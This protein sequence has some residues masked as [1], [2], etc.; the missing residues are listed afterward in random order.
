MFESNEEKDEERR[1][2]LE[3]AFVNSF[4]L[5]QESTL[6]EYLS[7][8]DG[9]VEVQYV[10]DAILSSQVSKVRLP[11]LFPNAK[12]LEIEVNDQLITQARGVIL[13]YALKE[14]RSTALK[15]FRTAHPSLLPSCPVCKICYP[16]EVQL[17]A[18]RT[19]NVCSSLKSSTSS[20]DIELQLSAYYG[21]TEGKTVMTKRLIYST[22]LGTSK[23]RNSVTEFSP[24]RPHISDT[25]NLC[26]KSQSNLIQ[27]P[28]AHD[29]KS[30]YASELESSA[31][32]KLHTNHAIILQLPNA[33][34]TLQQNLDLPRDGI[35]KKSI[36]TAPFYAAAAHV[37]FIVHGYANNSI[38]LLGKP[39]RLPSFRF[40]FV[41][42]LFFLYFPLSLIPSLIF[43]LFSYTCCTLKV[44]YVL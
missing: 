7:T 11:L 36:V 39:F 1:I 22:L 34:H 32:E 28:R 21:G 19:S 10:K 33:V 29:P 26:I 3:N 30:L 6:K 13:E 5:T 15:E 27:L 8:P 4:L 35:V 40:F 42:F 18:H 37:E 41:H 2:E 12:R 44:F 38:T 31:N 43:I 25:L 17:N 9:E 24:Y 14:A 20:R 16:N 23:W